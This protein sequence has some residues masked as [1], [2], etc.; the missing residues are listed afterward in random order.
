M[1]NPARII[2][3]YIIHGLRA[4]RSVRFHVTMGLP[5]VIIKRVVIDCL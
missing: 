5:L 2:H 3:G 4:I 1:L